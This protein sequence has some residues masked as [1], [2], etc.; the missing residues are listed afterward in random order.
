V[1]ANNNNTEMPIS[2]RLDPQA[3]IFVARTKP[4][5][6]LT[7][8]D[9][10]SRQG[11]RVWMPEITPGCTGGQHEPNQ[12]EL[13]FPQHILLQPGHSGHSLSPAGSTRGIAELIYFGASLATLQ[14]TSLWELTN[15][16]SRLVG[17]D[18]QRRVIEL[19]RLLEQDTLAAK[20]N[21]RGL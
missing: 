7:A 9:H 17:M 20:N 15:R 3:P 19:M 6:E 16:N 4:H 12:A 1:G 18:P 5:Q 8:H 13:L 21:A 10:L 2:H 11:Y 14:P